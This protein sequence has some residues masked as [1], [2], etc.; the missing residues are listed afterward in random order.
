M[1]SPFDEAGFEIIPGILSSTECHALV[2]AVS[3]LAISQGSRPGQRFAGLRNLLQQCRLVRELASCAKLSAQLQSLVG[4]PVFPVR[5]LFLD[6][7]E[8]VNWRV[9]WHQDCTV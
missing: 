9:T 4:Q 1:N 7:T 8:S 5:A 2:Q 3:A 6:K